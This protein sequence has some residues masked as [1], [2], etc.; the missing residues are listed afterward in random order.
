MNIERKIFASHICS[1]S[2]RVRWFP[3]S[4]GAVLPQ[5]SV[6]RVLPEQDGAAPENPH[7]RAA[8]PVHPLPQDVQP[9]ELPQATLHC[10][11]AES[12]CPLTRCLQ[13]L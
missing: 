11:P 10:A 9:E 2:T 13:H 4:A 7:G 5:V 6:L 3:E 12:S 1:L 8:I